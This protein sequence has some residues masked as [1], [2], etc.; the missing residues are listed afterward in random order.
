MILNIHCMRRLSDYLIL[1]CLSAIIQLA[2][3]E[4]I[5]RTWIVNKEATGDYSSIS[6]A[7][8]FAGPEDTVLVGAGEY[9]EPTVVF[10]MSLYISLAKRGEPSTERVA[11]NVIQ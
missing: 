5:A 8:G 1:F 3:T 6:V 10:A 11:F 2:T 4:S 9:T 7:V